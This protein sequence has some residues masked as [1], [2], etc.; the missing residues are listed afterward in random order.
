M[1]PAARHYNRFPQ[2]IQPQMQANLP[3][4]ERPLEK[5]AFIAVKQK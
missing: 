4:T 2:G 5:Q 1:A 3:G